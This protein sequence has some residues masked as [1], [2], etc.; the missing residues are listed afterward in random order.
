[1]WNGVLIPQLWPLG[2]SPELFRETSAALKGFHRFHRFHVLKNSGKSDANIANTRFNAKA[3]KVQCTIH[4]HAVL[5]NFG[6]V[7]GESGAGH[8]RGSP[9]ISQRCLE[10]KMLVLVWHSISFCCFAR[11]PEGCCFNIFTGNLEFNIFNIF[12][13]FPVSHIEMCRGWGRWTSSRTSRCGCGRS[14]PIPWSDTT[15]PA[16]ATGTGLGL[17]QW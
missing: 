7:F 15:S 5:S 3:S 11:F 1:M 9:R 6:L 4:C 13:T 2:F 8:L 17:S 12:N 10:G 16:S 14:I